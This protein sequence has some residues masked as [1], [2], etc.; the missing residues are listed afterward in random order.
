ML[1]AVRAY[2]PPDTEVY[3]PRGGYFLW[4]ELPPHVDAMQLFDDAMDNGVSLAPGPIFSVTGAFHRY[5]RLNY[6]RPWTPAVEDAMRTIGTLAGRQRQ[7][8]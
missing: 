6:G 5:V 3:A 4:I 2:F 8:R 7:T 1:A